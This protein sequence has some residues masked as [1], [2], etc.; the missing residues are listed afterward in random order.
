MIVETAFAAHL[1]DGNSQEVFIDLLI[2]LQ[3][4]I[5]FL[6]CFFLGGISRVPLLPQELPA[7]D[8]GCGVLELPS[9]HSIPLVQ[10][11]GQIPMAPNPLQQ[12]YSWYLALYWHLT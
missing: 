10:P 11:Q 8:E 4:V 1:A 7:S 6:F 5:H 3:N 2:Q 12:Q 9:H